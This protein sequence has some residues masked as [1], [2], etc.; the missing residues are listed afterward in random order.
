MS[1]AATSAGR[2]ET[3]AEAEALL[4]ERDAAIGAIQ[5]AFE[6]EH[7]VADDLRS[8]L[9]VAIAEADR[10]RATAASARSEADA[11]S[12][13]L[14]RALSGGGMPAGDAAELIGH[15]LANAKLE[16]ASLTERL[17]AAESHAR[18]ARVAQH[19]ES[20]EAMDAAAHCRQSVKELVS[21]HTA[22]DGIVAGMEEASGTGG[23]VAG[24][25]GPLTTASVTT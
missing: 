9:K 23:A 6:A 20:R 4:S 12:E 3:L 13:K 19:I 15:E 2:F 21:L 16:V 1:E 18:A 11:A 5:A 22:F 14:R 10:Q 17:V 8:A 24:T 7:T 25:D